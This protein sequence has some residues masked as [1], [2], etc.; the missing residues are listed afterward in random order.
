M[1]DWF[2]NLRKSVKKEIKDCFDNYVSDCE[3]KIKTNTKCFFSFNMLARYFK[4]VINEQG[5]VITSA[6]YDPF[7]H[8]EETMPRIG[9]SRITE[10]QVKGVLK[11]F[12]VNKVASPD[13]I[14]MLFFVSLSSSLSLPLS[15]LF[16]K[17]LIE[18]KFTKWKT[19]FV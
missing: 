6:I 14:P 8:Q 15:I 12:D 4:S 10:V 9:C 16:N 13:A 3:E 11:M 18:R 5:E 1:K 19:S 17:S 7:V 2:K